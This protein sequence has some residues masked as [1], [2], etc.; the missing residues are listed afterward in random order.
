MKMKL[1]LTLCVATFFSVSFLRAQNPSEVSDRLEKLERKMNELIPA[2]YSRD[3][4]TLTEQFDK[5]MKWLQ[6]D[7]VGNNLPF[8]YRGTSVSRLT[9]KIDAL[10]S[11]VN[12]LTGSSY[13]TPNLSELSNSISS[14]ERK[15]DRLEREVSD[16]QSEVSNLKSQ[17]R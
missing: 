16:L 13:S 14:M 8:Y 4:S 5:L 10:E 3:G 11:K 2:S 15:I 9:E 1:F 17:I 12:N 6:E 7:V